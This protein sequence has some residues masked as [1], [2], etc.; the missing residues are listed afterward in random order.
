[1]EQIS[2]NNKS[3]V[4]EFICEVFLNLEYICMMG[5]SLKDWWLLRRANLTKAENAKFSSLVMLV[6]WSVWRERNS[7]VFEKDF[8]PI[9]V[10]IF[11][12]KDVL[13]L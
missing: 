4:N 10:L 11:S 2:S 13:L 12:I 8:K 1:M 3:I 6:I 7:R 5:L 9:N